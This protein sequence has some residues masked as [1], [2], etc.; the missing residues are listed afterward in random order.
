VTDGVR[1]LVVLAGL[2]TAPRVLLA[3][4][5]LERAPWAAADLPERLRGFLSASDPEPRSDPGIDRPDDAAPTTATRADPELGGVIGTVLKVLVLLFVAVT[6]GL[7]LLR[8]R[9]TD[10]PSAPPPRAGPAGPT[11]ADA[12]RLRDAGSFREAVCAYYLIA[13]RRVLSLPG[14]AARDDLPD[15]ALAR[16]L[17]A[18][19]LRPPFARL[20][21]LFQPARYGCVPVAADDADEARTLVLRIEA[22][23]EEVGP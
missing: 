18:S 19:P 5:N 15:G 13:W 22:A 4:P 21:A 7:Y 8:R 10:R 3:Q 16:V 11:L 1:A 20:S 17:G 2:V 23:A 9:R 14:L 12:D 6:T